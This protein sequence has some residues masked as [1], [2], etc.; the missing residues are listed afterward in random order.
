[1][2]KKIISK[3]RIDEISGVDKPAQPGATVLIMKRAT[4]QDPPKE[5]I[6]MDRAALLALIAKFMQGGGTDAD[7]TNIR[8]GVTDLGA[9]AA[10]L[11]PITDLMVVQKADPAVAELQKKYE[12]MEK[13]SKVHTDQRSYFDTLSE[14]DQD[15]FLAKSAEDRATQVTNATAKDPVVYTTM[16]GT[17]IRKSAGDLMV[18]LAKRSD[19]NARQLAVEKA[20][21]RDEALTKRAEEEL[22][23]ITGETEH[24]KALLKAIDS[25]PDD[26][27]RDEVLKSLK[28]ANTAAGDDFIRKG[29]GDEGV[30]K[31]AKAEDQLDDLA[32]R[33][34]GAHEGVTYETAYDEVLKTAPGKKLYNEM[35]A[36]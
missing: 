5:T 16:D 19:D 14:T 12:R 33:Y 21:R 6:T 24:R 36:V 31:N 26:K 23:N 27:T 34:Q 8:K 35:V 28:A 13:V 32:K 15:A 3:L 1:M 2:V 30:R 25:I 18:S 22:S 10:D 17:E 9:A 29:T 4:A 20:A 7:L 11:K